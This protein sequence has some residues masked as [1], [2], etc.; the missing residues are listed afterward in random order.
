MH[1]LRRNLD[2]VYIIENNGVYGLTK[3]QFSASA[4]VGS[5]AKRGE[6]NKQPPI[7]PVQIALALGGSF[8]A[9]SFSG[10]KDQLVPLIKAGVRHRGFALIDVVSPVRHVQRSRRLHEELRIHARVQSPRPSMRTSCRPLPRS[11]RRTTR[12][13]CLPVD[14]HD[15]SRVLL[16]KVAKNYDRRNRGAALEYI[17][18]RHRN[19]EIVTG[20]LYI[21]ERRSR[22]AR[23]QRHRRRA[24]GALAVRG[25]VPRPGR[26]SKTAAA[27][28]LAGERAVSI[29]PFPREV[30]AGFIDAPSRRLTHVT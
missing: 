27:L 15:G 6:V 23:R 25:A 2:M 18:A 8:V 7:D 26:A 5:K 20:L 21:D 17:R 9:R 19:G 10:D 24:A 14:L 30:G 13:R 12:A 1:A 3:G 22:H 29:H 28:P 11:K 4:D 16:R